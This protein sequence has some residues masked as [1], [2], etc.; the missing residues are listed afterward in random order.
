MSD[1]QDQQVD[2][3]PDDA[4]RKWTISRR[5]F[6]IGMATTGA[7]LAL[8]I[9]LGLPPLRRAAA[10]LTEGDAG[11][12]GGGALDP[13]LW[14][15]VYPDGRVLI[16][17][18]KAE[19]GQ[20]IHTALAQIAAEELEVGWE[21]LE[22]QHASTS[23]A[24]DNF[25]GT[26]GSMSVTTLYDPLRQAAATL[27]ETLR[28][29]AA[30]AL[31][32]PAD[33][34]VARDG[35][36]E[37]AGD[38]Q[39]RVT[40]G[41]LASRDVEWQVPEE[42]VPLKPSSEYR[43]LGQSLPRVDLPSKVTGDAVFSY[44]ARAEGVLYGAA[45]H[46]PAI[47]ANM[48]SARP[49]QAADMPGVVKVVIED[50][51]VGVVAESRTQA[52]AAR[53]A[54]E[55]EWDE[56]HLWQQEELEELVT[57]GGRG[58]VN[59][60]RDGNAPSLLKRGTPFTAEYR[61]GMAT[62]APMEPEAA[63]AIIG[64]DGGRVWTATQFEM[65]ARREVAEALD[66]EPEQIEVI[67]TYLGGGFGRKIELE[68][69]PSPAVE[70][71]RLSRAV[72]APVHVGWD[73]FE[74]MRDGFVR[75]LTHHQLSAVLDDKGQIEALMHEQASG[76]ALFGGFPAPVGKVLGFD[77]GS[78]RGAQILYGIANRDTTV[79]RRPMPI[80]TG[81]WRG[82][83]L[84][85]NVFALESFIDELAHVAGA[86]PFQFRLTHLADDALGRR[87]AT[88]LGAAAGRAGWSKSLP[89]DQ[90]QGIACSTDGGTV[91]A[92]VAEVSLDQES[93][94]IRVHR[95]V[96]A[97]DPGRVI[98]P[99]GARAQIEGSIVMGTS[100]ALLEEIT[101]KD[102]RV[103]AGNFDRYPLLRMAEAP[104]VETILLEAPDGRPRGLGEP[105]IGPIAPAIGNA[106]FAL[107]GVR[108]RHLPM[109]PD[110]VKAALGS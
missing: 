21:Q 11:G 82:L 100:A 31:D 72:G 28:A 8:G 58:G 24:D 36:F 78:T 76:D 53:N 48:R 108:L 94:R 105:P 61:S 91:V 103:Q 41:E 40:Y 15:E 17:V 4:E 75:P 25:R 96:A 104:E 95:V 50:G 73:R 107:A 18:P 2:Q 45:V 81:S 38:S 33:S 52:W 7:A 102:G 71:A 79:W 70:A 87:M 85:A 9:P 12:F 109:T 62:H 57:A 65:S 39:V 77:F 46:R 66:L 98:N 101:V 93:G 6:L 64:P 19:M 43:F 29:E 16:F 90:A 59:I 89:E 99:V 86:D 32:L 27:R 44:D 3:A 13:L 67:P 83:G 30:R 35:G 14:F 22:V 5:G 54:L 37:L 51:F 42:D 69:V 20:G 63:L 34:L 60:Q 26:S 92:E 110:R 23:Q 56:G 84:M 47:E 106:L 10:G 1:R 74:E 80:P 49:G 68:G 88:V 55:V 97:V